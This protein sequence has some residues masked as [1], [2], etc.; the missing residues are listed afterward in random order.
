MRNLFLTAIL[1]FSFSGYSKAVPSPSVFFNLS[2]RI[3][4]EAHQFVFPVQKVTS[5]IQPKHAPRLKNKIAIPLAEDLGI[6][7]NPVL[8]F[9]SEG[10]W[11]IAG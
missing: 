2:E 6:L 10:M 8:K 4:E 9:R 1:L 7:W 5:K 3:L 11:I